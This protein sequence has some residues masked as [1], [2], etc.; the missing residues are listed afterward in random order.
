MA[1]QTGYLDKAGHPYLKIRVWGLSDQFAAEFDAMIDTGFSGYLSLPL[2]QA[3]PLAL[4]LFGTTQYQLADGSMSPK[5]LAHGSVECEGEVTSGLI[6]LE[7]NASCGPLLGME[8][9]RQSKKILFLGRG[10]VFLVDEPPPN[11]AAGGQGQPST[12]DAPNENVDIAA[13]TGEEH[14]PNPESADSA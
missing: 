8:F 10:G 4:T 12:A 5:L 13:Q 2:V 9:L 3:F 1:L 14:E 7:A 6:A 11:I